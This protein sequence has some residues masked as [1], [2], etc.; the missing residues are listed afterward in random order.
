MTM[1]ECIYGSDR[2]HIGRGLA[3]CFEE[4][5][6]EAEEKGEPGKPEIGICRRHYDKHMLERLK[7]MVPQEDIQR[8]R[9]EM[10]EDL[11]DRMKEKLEERGWESIEVK[12]V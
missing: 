9:E 8:I 7:E 3:L 10:K 11:K 4:F 5:E 6:V 1:V 2:R 12:E